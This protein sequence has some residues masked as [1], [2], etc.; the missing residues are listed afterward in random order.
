MP[1]IRGKDKEGPYYKY[2]KTGH[3]Y[4]Y[5]AGDTESR[6]KAKKEAEL[7]RT[8]IKASKARVERGE[9]GSL[10]KYLKEKR[11]RSPSGGYYT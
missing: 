1:I 11:S 4:H 9:P 5:K 3:K 6:K 7:Q 10:K 8:A 2:G